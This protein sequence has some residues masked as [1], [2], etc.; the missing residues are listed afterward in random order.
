MTYD[1]LCDPD[2]EKALDEVEREF[3]PRFAVEKTTTGEV[4]H[5]CGYLHPSTQPCPP[6]KP[7]YITSKPIYMTPEQLEVIRQ[8]WDG[9]ERD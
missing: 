6:R 2:I 9:F 1:D 7:I 4:I 8:M 5:T 3:G